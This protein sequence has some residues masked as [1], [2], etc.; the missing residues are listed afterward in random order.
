MPGSTRII[1]NTLASY[2][3]LIVVGLAG[4]L[5]TP[6]A[7]RLL[8]P[9]DYGIFAVIGGSMTFLMFINVALSGGAQRHI[10]YSLGEQNHNDVRKWLT[11]SLLIHLVLAVVLASTALLASNWIVGKLLTLP[12]ARVPAA[13]WIYRMVI[14]AVVSDIISTPY[15]ALLMAH[16]EILSLSLMSIV[17]CLVLVTGV[18]SLRFLP[19][20]TLLWYAGIY[21]CAQIVFFLGPVLFGLLRYRENCRLAGRGALRPYISELLGYSS[22][23]LLGTLSLVVRAQGPAILLNH[24]LGPTVNSAYGIALQANG[25]ATNVSSGVVRATSPPIVKRHAAGDQSG[26]VLLSNAANRYA[27]GILWIV[28]APVLFETQFCLKVWLHNVPANTAAFVDLLVIALLLDQLTLGF[29]AS[30]QATGRIAA[31]Q[32]AIGASNILAI[33]VGFVL[34][35]SGMQATSVLWVGVATAVLAAV[36]RIL[37]ARSQAG[38]PFSIWFRTVILPSAACVLASTLVSTMLLRLL[39][40]GMARFSAILLAS[41]SVACFV[42]WRFGTLPEHR[43]KLKALA[44]GVVQ[45]LMSRSPINEAAEKVVPPF[46]IKEKELP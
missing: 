25:A 24:F 20:D 28:I 3:R 37:F 14:V 38:I 8:G 9:S 33:P 32:M 12:P 21:T 5:T 27:F 13:T 41:D 46:L 39:R 19:G 44:A 45:R 7:L 34:L 35:R 1:V 26:M 22:W 43:A 31:Y 23:Y 17:S 4:L 42:L 2:V 6:I 15:Q 11:A 10:A 40:P 29:A 30:I 18:V 36:C 16:E